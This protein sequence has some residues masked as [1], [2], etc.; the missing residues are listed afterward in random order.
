[1]NF[2]KFFFLEFVASIVRE[3]SDWEEIHEYPGPKHYFFIDLKMA[4]NSIDPSGDMENH[5]QVRLSKDWQNKRISALCWKL[6]V[7]ALKLTPY[8]DSFYRI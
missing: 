8:N 7:W 2:L 4:Q 3:I 6:P 5:R 1:M